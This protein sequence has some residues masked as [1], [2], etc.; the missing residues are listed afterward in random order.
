MALPMIN[1][2]GVIDLVDVTA[3]MVNPKV[4]TMLLE[5]PRITGARNHKWF[6]HPWVHV[7]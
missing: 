3:P 6:L 2:P 4:E 5:Y 7:E 1:S